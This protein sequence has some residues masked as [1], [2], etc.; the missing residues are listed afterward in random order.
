MTI[1]STG[2]RESMIDAYLDGLLNTEK[3]KAFE[4][5]LEADMQLRTEVDSQHRVDESLGRLFGPPDSEQIV[6]RIRRTDPARVRVV[7]RGRIYLWLAA[8]LAAAAALAFFFGG[9]DI[10]LQSILGNR[11][12]AP[13]DL[14]PKTL[15]AIYQEEVAGGFKPRMVCKNDL[16]FA[17]TFWER[18]GQTLGIATMPRGV[19]A[20]GLNRANTITRKTTHILVMVDG[21]PVLVFVDRAD[22]DAG[23]SLPPDS[24]LNLFPRRMGELVIYEVSPLG[25]ARVLEYLNS[26]EYSAEELEGAGW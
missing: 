25:E 11:N 16:Q 3:L 18:F 7:S 6:E 26:P 4:R 20:I 5:E 22:A 12:I 1:E 23:Q 2:E 24:G 9:G 15:A 21:T 14:S 10:L 13:L 8:P 19:S 17:A